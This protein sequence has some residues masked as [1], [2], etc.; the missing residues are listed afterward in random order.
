ML[1][2]IIKTKVIQYI[3]KHDATTHGKKHCSEGKFAS[4]TARIKLALGRYER[5]PHLQ[6][7]LTAGTLCFML[8]ETV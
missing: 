1:I 3:I 7:F 8:R 4:L 5:S 2:K 6:R